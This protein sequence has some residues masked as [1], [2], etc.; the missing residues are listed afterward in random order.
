MVMVVVGG[1]SAGIYV[2]RL[3]ETLQPDFFRKENDLGPLRNK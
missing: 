3:N 1:G 2:F